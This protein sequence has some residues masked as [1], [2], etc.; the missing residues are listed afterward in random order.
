M[1]ASQRARGFTA[2]ELMIV[3]ALAAI[4]LMV[5]APGLVSIRRNSE[6]AAAAN[7]LVAAINTG[8][9]E[10]M[11][12]GVTAYAVP[13][14]G[15][16][17]SGGVTVFV[18]KNMDQSFTPGVDQVVFTL[19]AFPAYFSVTGTGTAAGPGAYIS[20]DGSGYAK[21][22]SGGFGALT[23]SIARND[24]NAAQANAQ[25]RRIIIASTGRLRSCRPDQ[26]ATC[27]ASATQ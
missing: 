23:L 8:R 9:S 1:K 7:A 16:D 12:R 11:K 5:A 25:T 14:D 26:D 27:T 15:H 19:P 3:V 10:A 13:T 18:D 4:L 17:W 6:L 2:V 22:K 21:T 24:V 20:Y